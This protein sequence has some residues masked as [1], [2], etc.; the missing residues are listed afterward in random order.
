MLR[1]ALINYVDTPLTTDNN[2][3]GTDLFDTSTHFHP[4]E[5]LSMWV[6]RDWR[7]INADP[8]LT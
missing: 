3:V 7:V 4:L 1:L 5:I 8:L 6:S 2:V